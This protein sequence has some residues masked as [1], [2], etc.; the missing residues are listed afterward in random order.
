MRPEALGLLLARPCSSVVFIRIH[1]MQ[2]SPPIWHW[3]RHPAG[4]VNPG[5]A[6]SGQASRPNSLSVTKYG[7][8][9]LLSHSLNTAWKMNI[10]CCFTSTLLN[11]W[12]VQTECKSASLVFTNK[13]CCFLIKYW[14]YWTL[15]KLGSKINYMTL[16]RHYKLSSSAT[17]ATGM[18]EVCCF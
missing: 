17:S 8:V 6:T 13:V 18:L 4:G 1:P 10:L 9:S 3:N 15:F 5:P 11:M 12:A 16:I 7:G 14:S 2:S